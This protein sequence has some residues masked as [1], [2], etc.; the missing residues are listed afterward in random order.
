[1][2]TAII[3]MELQATFYFN[4]FIIIP[5]III[6]IFAD[7]NIYFFGIYKDFVFGYNRTIIIILMFC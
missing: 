7:T 3:L 1:M 2:N 6:H 4:R 5:I